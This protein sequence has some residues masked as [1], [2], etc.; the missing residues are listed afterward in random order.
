MLLLFLLLSLLLSFYKGL[1]KFKN[2][3]CKQRHYRSN[4]FSAIGC[5]QTEQMAGSIKLFYLY[6]DNNCSNIVN[7][8]N[9]SGEKE[10]L[11]KIECGTDEIFLSFIDYPTGHVKVIFDCIQKLFLD[12]KP[13]HLD[14]TVREIGLQILDEYDLFRKLK[15]NY[16]MMARI[17]SKFTLYAYF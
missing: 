8:G 7:N 11:S 10:K 17:F 14:Y 6:E 4:S 16:F 15:L 3:P 1:Q 2:S 12:I 9:S 5:R 13:F